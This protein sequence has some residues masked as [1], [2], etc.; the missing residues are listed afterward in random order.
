MNF[1]VIS[2][3]VVSIALPAFSLF[4]SCSYFPVDCCSSRLLFLALVVLLMDGVEWCS[5]EKVGMS[6]RI[7]GF[8][9]S[10]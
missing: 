5:R 10:S 2:Y 4:A 9:W 7:P 1:L 3:S 6:A 8:L